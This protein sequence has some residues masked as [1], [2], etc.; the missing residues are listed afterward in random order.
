MSEI[1]KKINLSLN[2][3]IKSKNFE[4]YNISAIID[5]KM[6]SWLNKTNLNLGACVL[7]KA[8][9]KDHTKHWKH[10]N[11]VTRLNYVKAAQ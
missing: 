2:E 7:V 3:A 4:G 11:D 9:V 6:V 10:Q 1:F 8:K 5:N